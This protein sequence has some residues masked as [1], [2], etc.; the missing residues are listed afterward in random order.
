M[1]FLEDTASPMLV[2]SKVLLLDLFFYIIHHAFLFS[3]LLIAKLINHCERLA[4]VAVTKNRKVLTNAF[5]VVPV[6]KEG[7]LIQFEVNADTFMSAKTPITPFSK[8]EDVEL[9]NIFP[10]KPTISIPT[11]NIY[12][13]QRIYRKIDDQLLFYNFT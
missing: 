5:F 9:P 2:E 4:G 11:E 12:K 3:R 10:I 1:C 7:D 13:Q 6:E 8:V